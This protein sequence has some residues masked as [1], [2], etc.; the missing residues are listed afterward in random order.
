LYCATPRIT[1]GDRLSVVATLYREPKSGAF[2][3]KEAVILMREESGRSIGRCTLDLA[4][5][6]AD[7]RNEDLALKL[8]PSGLLK[9][10]LA[11]AVVVAD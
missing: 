3:A 10:S 4:N 5:Y 2:D 1:F 6:A 11:A 8:R 7:G 9:V